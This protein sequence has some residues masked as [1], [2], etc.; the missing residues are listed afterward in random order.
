MF[1]EDDFA[2]RCLCRKK[3]LLDVIIPLLKVSISCACRVKQYSTVQ[4]LEQRRA[5]EEQ[6]AEKQKERWTFI[7]THGK[8]WY[9][10]PVCDYS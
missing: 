9:L 6:L 8:L 1:W 4:E 5:S 2:I 7:L 3:M 10:K